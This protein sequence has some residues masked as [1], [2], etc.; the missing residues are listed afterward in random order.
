MHVSISVPDWAAF[1]L[2]D[3]S[4]WDRNPQPVTEHVRQTATWHVD[5]PD[6]VYFEY[7]FID[8]QGEQRPD[9]NNDR[10][11]DNPWFPAARVITGP[12]YEPDTYAALTL[13]EAYVS[14]LG[15]VVRGRIES[16]Q[17]GARRRY[18]TYTP[19]GYEGTALPTIY[20]QDGV[21][22]YR[23]AKLQVVL[24]AL[25]QQE[26]LRPAHLVFIEPVSR[27]T[28]YSF[29]QAYWRFVTD[30]LVPDV[31]RQLNCTNERV[32]MGASLGGFVS[33]CIAWQN[34]DMFST[35]I[36][37]SG[38]F[39]GTLEHKDA[40]KSKESW[41]LETLK[42]NDAKPLR[43]YLS[44]G[45]MDWLTD[46]NRQ[47]ADVLQSKG[48]EVIHTESTSGHNWVTWKNDFARALR[49]ALRPY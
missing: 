9:P 43:W 14:K 12:S 39:L 27:N 15:T 42:D 46:I 45:T 23:Y 6:D 40:Y 24:E 19:Q 2:S 33:A 8:A 48:Y 36:T 30:E 3:L 1:I 13:S 37:Q 20:L 49:F 5:L 10:H 32:A 16:Q 21:A 28:D 34:P 4:D 7:A 44:C 29:N 31:E 25:I 17:L 26:N 47:M 22:Y 35:V 38:A 11:A 18:T 41:L